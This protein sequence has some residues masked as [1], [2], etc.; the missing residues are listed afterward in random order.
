MFGHGSG[1]FLLQIKP[2]NELQQPRKFERIEIVG[3]LLNSTA[4]PAQFEGIWAKLV[5]LFSRQI[6]NGSHHYHFFNFFC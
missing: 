1:R 5:S 4:N 6:A 2:S 3:A